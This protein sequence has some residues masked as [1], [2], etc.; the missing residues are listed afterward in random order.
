MSVSTK[1]WRKRGMLLKFFLL[2][3]RKFELIAKLSNIREAIK[4]FIR[5]FNMRSRNFLF[6]LAVMILAFRSSDAQKSSYFYAGTGVMSLPQV[7]SILEE[8]STIA[9]TGGYVTSNAK[10]TMPPLYLGY[11]YRVTDRFGVGASY[12]YQQLGKELT[13]NE[14]PGGDF[15]RYFNI[16]MAEVD[17]EWVKTEWFAVYL[18]AGAGICYYSE[19]AKYAGRLQKGD[20]ITPAFQ[21]TP[22]GFRTGKD[23]KLNIG[24]GFGYKGSITAGL[25]MRL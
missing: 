9:L 1:S 13:L 20:K 16:F 21:V 2:R 11:Q 18:E 6:F 4:H 5:S 10:G 15:Y 14:V 12:T 23:F 19:E 8:V 25:G 3:G 17:Y 7:G 24:I 22:I